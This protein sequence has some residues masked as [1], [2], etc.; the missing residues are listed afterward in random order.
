MSE[1][2]SDK[3]KSFRI[4]RTPDQLRKLLNSEDNKQKSLFQD[5]VRHSRDYMDAFGLNERDLEAIEREQGHLGMYPSADDFANVGVV[6]MEIDSKK[7]ALF[8]KHTA[9]HD[10]SEGA[11]WQYLFMASS[12]D[13]SL[14]KSAGYGTAM[15]TAIS[16]EWHKKMLSGIRASAKTDL[17]GDLFGFLGKK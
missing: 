5:V 8:A 6:Q 2:D 10:Y 3:P 11:G 15:I 4:T 9:C 13:A 17:A 7:F 12:D 14:N 1:Q 16:E